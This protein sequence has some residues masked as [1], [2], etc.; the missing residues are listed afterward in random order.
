[1]R[2]TGKGI[3]RRQNKMQALNNE[4]NVK[5]LEE[6]GVRMNLPTTIFLLNSFLKIHFFHNFFQPNVT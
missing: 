2:K 5:K 1:M 3:K 4:K 6:R